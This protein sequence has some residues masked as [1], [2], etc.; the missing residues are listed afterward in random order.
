VELDSGA[1]SNLRTKRIPD[2]NFGWS[3]ASDSIF[4]QL[5]RLIE[6]AILITR[7]NP[8]SSAAGQVVE[9]DTT[10]KDSAAPA[11]KQSH[12]Y[13]IIYILTPLPERTYRCFLCR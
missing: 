9:H 1:S 6:L 12:L 13:W 10:M 2:H 11:N 8:I 5:R 4:D 3:S 7:A